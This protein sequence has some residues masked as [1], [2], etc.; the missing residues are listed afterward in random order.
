MIVIE[1]LVKSLRSGFVH[2]PDVQAA[3]AC[4]MWPDRDRQWEAV[5]PRLQD[6]MPELF[7]LGRSEFE[8]LQKLSELYTDY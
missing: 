7:V 4:I 1:A 3:P 8:C 5:I 6:K 2:N